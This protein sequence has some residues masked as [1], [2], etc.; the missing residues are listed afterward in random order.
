MR[1]HRRRIAA[2]L[3]GMI[4]S[5]WFCFFQSVSPCGAYDR[6]GPIVKAVRAVSPAVVNI[7]SV[8][9]ARKRS[10][11]FSGFGLNPFFDSFFK[12]FFDPYLERQPERSTLGSGVILDGKRGLIITNAHVIA[13]AGTRESSRPRLSV[14]TPISTWRSCASSPKRHCRRSKWAKATT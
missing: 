7:S 10:G 2:F 14:P 4:V 9:S 1:G 6:E 13:N 12:D 8:L 3:F 5:A 11:P